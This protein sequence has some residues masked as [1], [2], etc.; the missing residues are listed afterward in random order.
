MAC[1]KCKHI[2]IIFE[3]SDAG[4]PGKF[5]GIENEKGCTPDMGVWELRRDGFWAFRIT[6]DQWPETS[7]N[8]SSSKGQL[9][10]KNS[11][12]VSRVWSRL[13]TAVPTIGKRPTE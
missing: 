11:S 4:G 7:R 3:V 6:E 1:R 13:S 12:R 2:D 9:T 10:A 5:V 8:V